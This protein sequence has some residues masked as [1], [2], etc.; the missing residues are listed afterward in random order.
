MTLAADLNRRQSH[1][2]CAP[3]APNVFRNVGEEPLEHDHV[4]P[5]A[6]GQVQGRTWHRRDNGW[7]GHAA[8]SR[9]ARIRAPGLEADITIEDVGDGKS[10]LRGPSMPPT[11]PSTAATA[12]R[13][14]T[15]W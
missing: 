7:F 5:A 1:G 13:P 6:S 14:L 15:A 2:Q 11:A 4:P 10:E 3:T 8:D 12:K 9:R